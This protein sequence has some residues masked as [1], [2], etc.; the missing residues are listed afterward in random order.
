[1]EEQHVQCVRDRGVRLLLAMV[2]V[3]SAFPLLASAP[4]DRAVQLET[5]QVTATRIPVAPGAVPASISVVSGREL[6]QRGATDLRSALALLAGVDIS[7]G[8]DGGPA[9]SVPALWGLREFDAFLLVIDGVPWGGAFN[10][11]LATLVLSNVE[12]IEVLRGSAP[13][14]YGATSFVGV[15]HVI[16]HA[17]GDAEQLA[18][19]AWGSFDSVTV[20]ASSALPPG[21][22]YRHSLAL[23]GEH[24]GFSGPRAGVDRG[25]L[26][27]RGAVDALDGELRLDADL[28]S[29]RQDPNSP[30]LREGKVLAPGMPLDANYNPAD[31]RLDQDRYHLVAAYERRLAGA[32]WSTTLA[33][34]HSTDDIIRGF[35]DE[36]FEDDGSS[37]NAAGFIQDRDTDDVYFD[38]HLNRS[39]GPRLELTYGLDYL[40]GKAHQRS[41]NFDYYVPADGAFAPSSG[42]SA[43]AESFALRD[44]RNFFGAYLQF[45]WQLSRTVHALAGLRLNHTRERRH[46]NQDRDSLTRTRLGGVIGV[47][48]RVFEQ[49][50]DQVTLFADYRNT[51]K[52]AAIDFGPE[53]EAEILQPETAASYEVGIKTQMLQGLLDVDFSAFDMHFDNLVVTQSVGGRPGLVNAGT[54]HFKGAEVETRWQLAPDL[55]VAGHYAWHEARF[56]DYVQLFDG[57]PTQLEGNY[58]EMSPRR[59]GGLGLIYQPAQGLYGSLTWNHVG[60]RYL[61]KRNTAS[62]PAYDTLDASLGYRFALWDVGFAGRNLRDARP[63]V[64]ESEIGESQYYRLPARYCEVFVARRF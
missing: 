7:P 26:L 21:E 52:P 64:A 14:M 58:L 34:T 23:D 3:Y 22:R 61:N 54:E 13:V 15:I 51:Y 47:N 11:A 63:P 19:V 25:H 32:D 56:G 9:A 41:D 17:A 45:G 31:A 1:M 35:V 55:M 57:I 50:R 33:V 60:R 40:Y 24:R 29:L 39:F 36:A 59:L 5:V 46:A 42:S 44:E 53:S 12:R 62:T 2:C 48:W 38:S 10:P 30:H 16:H 43:V 49:G 6:A 27:Y 18:R 8:G 28:S 20:S 4:P 37:P